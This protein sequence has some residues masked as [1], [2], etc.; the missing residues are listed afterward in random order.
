M[1]DFDYAYYL[2]HFW[3]AM[4]E[5]PWRSKENWVEWLLGWAWALA[6]L[7]L[8]AVYAPSIVQFAGLSSSPYQDWL[9]IGI[10]AT[11]GFIVQAGSALFL[12]LLSNNIEG[13]SL[14]DGPILDLLDKGA[15]G[16]FVGIGLLLVVGVVLALLPVVAA[17]YGV[18]LYFTSLGANQRT[19]T[20]SFVGALLVKTFLIP[21]IKSLVTGAAFKVFVGWLRGGKK[22][23][24][25]SAT[26]EAAPQNR[27][28]PNP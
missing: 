28:V 24:P 11:A 3:L 16:W 19:V 23:G 18:Y 1:K 9:V 10:A 12:A 26:V 15:L 7:V 25:Q 4:L 17:G 14:Y 6:G 5:P 27:N 20:I 8:G 2:K 13:S 21:F 22:K